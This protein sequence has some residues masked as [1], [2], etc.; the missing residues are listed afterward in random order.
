[1]LYYITLTYKLLLD[2]SKW[3]QWIIYKNEN[4]KTINFEVFTEALLKN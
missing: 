4:A 3:S 1:M 2:I